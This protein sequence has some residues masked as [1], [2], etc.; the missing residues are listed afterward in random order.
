MHA[1]S[2]GRTFW[3]LTLPYINKYTIPKPWK[4]WTIHTFAYLNGLLKFSTQDHD[5]VKKEK[6]KAA[7]I[8]LDK[9][10]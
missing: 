7:W 2:F 6:K 1:A 3:L 10:L 5:L 9:L 8:M 4:N